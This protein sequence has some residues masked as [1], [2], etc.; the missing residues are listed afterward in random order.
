M[1]AF[2]AATLVAFWLSVTVGLFGFRETTDG[3]PQLLCEIAEVV[4][5]VCALAA[6]TLRRVESRGDT[7]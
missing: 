4:A 2:G 1:L 5:V 3:V 6:L 7:R